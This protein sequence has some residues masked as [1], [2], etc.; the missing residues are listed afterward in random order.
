[1]YLA[2][3]V[4]FGG[5]LVF[6]PLLYSCLVVPGWAYSRGFLIGFPGLI[7]HF[8]VFLGVLT[9]RTTSYLI[10]LGVFLGGLGVFFPGISLARL[11]R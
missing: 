3:T 2:G 9:L 5:S 10:F 8:A 4:K 6:I 7:S 1:M 11:P